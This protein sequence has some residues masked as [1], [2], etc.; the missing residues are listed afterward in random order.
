MICERINKPGLKTAPLYTN[1]NTGHSLSRDLSYT[2]RYN[3]V[4][5]LNHFCLAP[6][7]QSVTQSTEIRMLSV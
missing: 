2:L 5:T 7:G 3:D 6:N 4:I 1:L